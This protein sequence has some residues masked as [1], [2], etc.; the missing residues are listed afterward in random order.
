MHGCGSYWY[1][2]DAVYIEADH[3][4]DAIFLYRAKLA[5]GE[6]S[7]TT[8]LTC[9][10]DANLRKIQED[11]RYRLVQRLYDDVPKLQDIDMVR[12][13]VSVINDVELLRFCLLVAVEMHCVVGNWLGHASTLNAVHDSRWRF[14]RVLWGLGIN[15]VGSA[16]TWRG[17][18]IEAL[19]RA[20]FRASED[21]DIR[22]I[23]PGQPGYEYAKGETLAEFV[24]RCPQGGEED[25]YED[26]IP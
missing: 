5:S 4:V 8:H 10:P 21:G 20:R 3:L 24:A 25:H 9:I 14:I 18:L 11:W 23:L 17:S 22:R 16:L 1:Q 26:F 15:M 7:G 12:S 6:I 2:S 19:E 13:K